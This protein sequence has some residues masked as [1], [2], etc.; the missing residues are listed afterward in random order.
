M[1]TRRAPLAGRKMPEA[2]SAEWV[3]APA[4]AGSWYPDD[5][6]ELSAEIDGLLAGVTPVDGEPV[7]LIVPHAGYRYSGAVAAHGFKQLAGIPYEVAVVIAAD[8]RPPLAQPVSVWAKGAFATPL[9][10]VPVHAELAQAL[11]S[12]ESRLQFDPAAHAGEHPIEIELPFLQRVCPDCP[13][14]PILMGRSDEK[15]VDALSAAL[16][17]VLAGRRAVVIASSDLSHYPSA[18]D[19]RRVDQIT[20]AAIETG[21]TAQVRATLAAQ[22]SAGVPG[23][24]TAACSAGPIFV[25]LRVAAGLGAETVTVLNYANSGDVDWSTRARVVGYGAVMAWAYTPPDLTPARREALLTRAR[26][27][28]GA[29]LADAGLPAEPPDDAA[30]LRRAGVFVTLRRR[31]WPD[32]PPGANLRG[33]IGHVAADTPL[34]EIVPAMAVSAAG[35]DWRFPPLTAAELDQVGIEISVLSPMRRITD[36]RQI[37][38]GRHGLMLAQAGLR[39]LLL[40]EV[41]VTRGWNR[42]TFVEQT[43]H[44]A[45]LERDAWRTGAAMYTFSTVEFGEA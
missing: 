40:P 34:W 15:T 18:S 38:I 9:G 33:C 12:A 1:A 31:D 28:I 22:E 35:Q 3:R 6:A 43:C 14:I 32:E 45:G 19:A 42:R 5:S 20:L 37:E 4:V 17:Q 13:I 27:A 2:Y 10:L 24:V 8:H 30:L 26:A 11:L 21:D 44:K 39:G 25:A 29:F 16:L 7:A 23:L 36:I 41:A